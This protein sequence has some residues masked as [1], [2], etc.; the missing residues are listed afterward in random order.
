MNMF[1]CFLMISASCFL[2]GCASQQFSCGESP[3]KGQC[4]SLAKVYEKTDGDLNDYR[5]RVKSQRPLASD[6]PSFKLQLEH[7][8][9]QIPLLTKPQVM[10][11]FFNPFED[12]DSDL[13]LGGYVY[14]KVSES[15]WQ[16]KD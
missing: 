6:I 12:S 16:L 14:I 13:N 2:G 9:A 15:Q 5:G 3:Q 7:E 4:Q 10:R 8:Q 1:F 11:I